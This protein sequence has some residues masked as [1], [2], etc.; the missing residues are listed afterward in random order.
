MRPHELEAGRLSTRQLIEQSSLG[1]PAARKLREQSSL[2]LAR[3]IAQQ[4]Q[5]A[6]EEAVGFDPARQDH[7]QAA[8]SIPQTDDELAETVLKVLESLED[9]TRYALLAGDDEPDHDQQARGN[10]RQ[11][12]RDQPAL[13]RGGPFGP[14]LPATRLVKLAELPFHQR[15]IVAFHELFDL[16]FAEIGEIF[17]L[18]EQ[19]V[20]THYVNAQRRLHATQSS[21]ASSGQHSTRAVG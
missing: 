8:A 3:W 20:R 13:V 11:W 14:A 10:S 2:E 6:L 5:A 9:E 12:R 21:Q 7:A 17:A 19:A 1:T 4:S 16:S 15:Q 18:P